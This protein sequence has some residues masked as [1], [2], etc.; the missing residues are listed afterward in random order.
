MTAEAPAGS[1]FSSSSRSAA[2]LIDSLRGQID[3]IDDGIAELI[4]RRALLSR[5]AQE[6]RMAAG[7][8]RIELTRE[9]VVL[10]H[11][12]D[13]LGDSGVALGSVVLGLC[14]GQPPALPPNLGARSDPGARRAN[15]RVSPRAAA[16]RPP[17]PHADHDGRDAP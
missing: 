14:R 13:A 2:Q 7:G 12:R 9:R 5:R 17:F 4:M 6:V 10:Q 11:Y 8:V 3:E 16:S 15:L 1:D